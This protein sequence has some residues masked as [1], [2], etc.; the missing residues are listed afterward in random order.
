MI[1]YRKNISTFNFVDKVQNESNFITNQLENIKRIYGTLTVKKVYDILSNHDNQY[2]QMIK[3][4]EKIF[5]TYQ[6]RIF[7]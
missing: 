5:E 2:G 7:K 4:E 1:I 3:N 6:K